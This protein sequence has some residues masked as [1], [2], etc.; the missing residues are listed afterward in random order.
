MMEGANLE[1]SRPAPKGHENL[2]QGCNPALRARTMRRMSRR[3]A[4]IVAGRFIAWT[5]SQR[6]PSRRVRFDRWDRGLTRYAAVN[7]IAATDHTVP[8]GTD[9]SCKWIPGNEL[10]GYYHHVP[11]GQAVP[12]VDFSLILP[13]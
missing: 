11:P 6:S 4:M 12:P 1:R 3:D 7:E 8:Y 2:A 13:T 9:P 5:C 10:P